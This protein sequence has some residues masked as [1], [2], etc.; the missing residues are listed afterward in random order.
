MFGSYTN[1]VYFALSHSI[2]Q[3]ELLVWGGLEYSILNKL[4]I[5]QK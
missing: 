5:N 2:F 1:N 3:Y 4:Q